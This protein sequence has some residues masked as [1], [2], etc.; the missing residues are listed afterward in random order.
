VT[1]KK[2]DKLDIEQMGAV[3]FVPMIGK[4]KKGK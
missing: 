1:K 2:N 3:A 4:A